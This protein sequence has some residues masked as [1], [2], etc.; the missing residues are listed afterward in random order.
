MGTGMD[1][2]IRLRFRKETHLCFQERPRTVSRWALSVESLAVSPHEFADRTFYFLFARTACPARR[3][4]QLNTGRGSRREL[5]IRRQQQILIG[6][7]IVF[8]SHD[9]HH[10]AA[11]PIFARDR[12][13][14]ADT[15]LRD[16]SRTAAI[17][18]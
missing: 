1:P 17:S 18:R 15:E 10:C 3:E 16:I 11:R 2:G 9:F 5:A 8:E 4:V 12:L 6:K 13:S 7:M 14:E